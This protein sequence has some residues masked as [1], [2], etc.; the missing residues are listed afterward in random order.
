MNATESAV[1]GS[2]S[3]SH[4]R[5]ARRQAFGG[6]PREVTHAWCT[7]PTRFINVY[8]SGGDP[9]FP[10]QGIAWACGEVLRPGEASGCDRSVN[11]TEHHTHIYD[12]ALLKMCAGG[13]WAGRAP[14]SSGLRGAGIE[15]I[16]C[17]GGVVE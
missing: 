6:P 2:S 10:Q 13:T 7:E 9:D 12:V 8:K 11:R 1:Q 5:W 14:A 4:S 3:K 16:A 17:A 15:A